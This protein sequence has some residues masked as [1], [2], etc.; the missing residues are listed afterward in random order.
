MAQMGG[1]RLAEAPPSLKDGLATE[2]QVQRTSCRFGHARRKG[3][4]KTSGENSPARSADSQPALIRNHTIERQSVTDSTSPVLALYPC[5][6][7]ATRMNSLAESGS[8]LG[9]L[10]TECLKVLRG[11]NP[12]CGIAVLWKDRRG[13][14]HWCVDELPAGPPLARCEPRVSRPPE[15]LAFPRL[16]PNCRHASPSSDRRSAICLRIFTSDSASATQDHIGS[17]TR[18]LVNWVPRPAF[19]HEVRQTY[20]D[21]GQCAR[22]LIPGACRLSATPRATKTY[23]GI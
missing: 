3:R 10:S 14:I 6:L 18:P 22:L 4:E 21:R 5:Q 17:R 23:K 16:S 13:L 9:I 11:R 8:A 20:F 2:V 19:A 7:W 1:L 12:R 15:S